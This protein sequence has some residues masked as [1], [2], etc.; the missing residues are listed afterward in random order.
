MGTIGGNV[1]NGDPGNGMP[2][3]MQALDAVYRLQGGAG[4]REVRARDFYEGAFTTARE[5]G[6]I[7]T[8]I[9][10]SVPPA[11]HGFA[12]L[13]QKRKSGDCA[14]AAAA[15]AL[16]NVGD[17]PLFAEAAVEALVG[18]AVDKAAIDRAA[19]AAEA[20]THPS[21]DGRGP[22]EFRTKIA[23]VMVR[24]AI[25]QALK[26]A[27]TVDLNG[28]SEKSCMVLA[29]QAN[30]ADVVTVEGLAAADGTLHPLG[31]LRPGQPRHGGG[32][33]VHRSFCRRAQPGRAGGARAKGA[34]GTP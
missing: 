13:K 27:C 21:A 11:G 6:E 23:G 10:F 30:G 7:L 25:Q 17:T 18:S 22:A 19:L 14:T 8:A 20:I 33:A 28:K 15:V 5:Q 24:R 26:H 1:A 9:R 2:A 32:D 34:P 29:V 12:Y 16:T 4:S 3:V 31:E